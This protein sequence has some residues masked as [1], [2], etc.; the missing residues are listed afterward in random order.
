MP[1]ALPGEG[2]FAA[3]GTCLVV[4]ADGHAWFGTGGAKVARVF[5][6]T[7]RGRTWTV[8]ETPLRAGSPSA[9]IFSLAFWDADH[10]VA[11]GGD[12]K[13]PEEAGGTVARSS[14]GG[15]TWIPVPGI[16]AGGLPLGGR[17]RARLG[18]PGPGRGWSR[19]DGSFPGRR[20][21]L[22]AAGRSRL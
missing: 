9:G 7:D 2:A 8:A 11:V 15:R 20:R 18:R 1:P 22:A 10:G 16:G 19:R 17:R 4:G 6:S 3:S 13:Q 12:Y 5:R 21:E 14:D